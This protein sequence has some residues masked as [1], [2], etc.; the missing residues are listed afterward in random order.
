LREQSGHTQLWV[1]AEAELGTGY[2]QRLESGRVLQPEL[3]TLDRILGALAISYRERKELLELF[4]YTV[5]VLLPEPAEIDQARAISRRELTEV[6]FPAYVLD[7]AVRL[8]AWNEFFPRLFGLKSGEPLPSV[9]TRDTF[10]AAWFDPGSPLAPLIANPDEVRH[11][12]ITALRYEIRQTGPAPWQSEFLERMRRLPAFREIW[13]T[14]EQTAPPVSAARAL[15]P[16]RFNVT[17]AG[18]LEFRLSAEPFLRDSR[19]RIIYY[20]PADPATMQQCA[21][22]AVVQVTERRGMSDV[23]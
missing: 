4:G 13:E 17:G 19:F 5:P 15:V 8:I 14:L 18:R 16:L 22:W 23:R 3:P 20:F 6:P 2:L 10:L 21:D 9:L 12:L 1:E 11:A 7:C